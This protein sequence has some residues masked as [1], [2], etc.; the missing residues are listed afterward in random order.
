VIDQDSNLLPTY[1]RLPVASSFPSTSSHPTTVTENLRVP[2][3][4]RQLRAKAET[5][6]TKWR[7]DYDKTFAKHNRIEIIL[8]RSSHAVNADMEIGVKDRVRVTT[9]SH[10]SVHEFDMN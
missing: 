6:L 7:E 10:L 1:P 9:Y 5:R 2:E 3:L 4:A 8:A